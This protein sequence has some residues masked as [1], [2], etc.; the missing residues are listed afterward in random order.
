MKKESIIFGLGLGLGLLIG[1]YLGQNNKK[2]K[3][4]YHL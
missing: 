1:Y 4:A 2:K 3:K